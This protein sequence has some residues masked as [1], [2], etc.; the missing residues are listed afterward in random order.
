[1]S[2]FCPLIS[3]VFLFAA[4]L[5]T[6][7]AQQPAVEQEP[8]KAYSA[9]AGLP[10]CAEPGGSKAAELSIGAPVQVLEKKGE[11]A[12]VRM[13]GWVRDAHLSPR[14]ITAGGL[15]VAVES[16]ENLLSVVKHSLNVSDEGKNSEKVVLKI[17]LKN[18][19]KEAISS[20]QG[21]VV[22]IMDNKV[23]FREGVS[24]EQI[25]IPAGGTAEA[26]FEW[27]YREKLYPAVK[28]AVGVPFTLQLIR[29]KVS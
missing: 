21:I 17:T 7:W 10:M 4:A 19:S 28:S 25:K 13:E 29:V 12:R 15:E 23:L 24:Q 8:Q 9:K 5:N 3:T 22:G 18:N 6:V 16:G 20:W 1:M 14:P 11:W 26:E 2:K 27:N